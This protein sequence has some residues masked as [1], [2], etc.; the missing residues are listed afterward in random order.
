MF[1]QILNFVTNNITYSNMNNILL[2]V[3][4]IHIYDSNE[5]KNQNMI[6]NIIRFIFLCS[7]TVRYKK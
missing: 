4:T 1:D 3:Y 7:T 6:K 5:Y 2:D